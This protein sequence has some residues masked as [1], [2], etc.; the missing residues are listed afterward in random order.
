MKDKPSRYIPFENNKGARL[1]IDGDLTVGQLLKAGVKEIKIL[2]L[3]TPL[4]DGWWR[5][6][7]ENSVHEL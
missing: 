6:V 1:L 5:D 7:A 3:R 2:D 4:E